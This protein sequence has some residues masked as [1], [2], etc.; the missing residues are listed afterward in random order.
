MG[1]KTQHCRLTCGLVIT[2]IFF[3]TYTL[4]QNSGPRLRDYYRRKNILP[5]VRLADYDTDDAQEAKRLYPRQILFWTSLIKEEGEGLRAFCFKSKHLQNCP[6]KC[7]FT[8]DRS[9]FE[10][11]DAVVFD[12][13]NLKIKKKT[14][15]D[16]LWDEHDDIPEFRMHRQFW[17]FHMMEAPVHTWINLKPFEGLFNW[18]MT[19]RRDSDVYIPYGRLKTK[20]TEV[21]KYG[22]VDLNLTHSI[23]GRK[24]AAW[25]VS[26]C[27]FQPSGREQYAHELQKYIPVDIYGQCGSLNCTSY[28]GICEDPVTCYKAIG[29]KYKF[30]LAFENS[31]CVDYITEKFYNALRFGM[32]PVVFGYGDYSRVA[33]KS[34]YIEARSFESPKQLAEYLLFLHTHPEEYLKYFEWRKSYLVHDVYYFEDAWCSLCE[35]LWKT[36]ANASYQQSASASDLERWWYHTTNE[37]SSKPACQ[38]SM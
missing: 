10:I 22:T 8:T 16:W 34:S 29:P 20:Q 31:L 37:V 15:W 14:I 5:I 21:G 23:H 9:Y 25:V 12:C 2:L 28:N 11:A 27:R 7:D 26:N 38:H 13:R 32:V 19:Y 4:L 33:P 3:A 35:K 6:Y 18:T 36:P 17:V 24:L 30:Y 1:L